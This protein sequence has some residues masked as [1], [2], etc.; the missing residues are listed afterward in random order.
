MQIVSSVA[1][2]TNSEGLLQVN[3][4]KETLMYY[5]INDRCRIH[6]PRSICQTMHN[7]SIDTL[8]WIHHGSS[9]K[10]LSLSTE[11]L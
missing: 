3:A 7:H 2:L 8:L 6:N 5:Y 4:A 11:T 9:G 1:L 10:C